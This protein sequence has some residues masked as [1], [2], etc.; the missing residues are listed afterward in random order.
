[1]K[2]EEGNRSEFKFVNSI[3]TGEASKNNRLYGTLG[4]IFGFLF[5][6][7]F[8]VVIESLKASRKKLM[9]E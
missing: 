1:M 6:V 8:I 7:L 3:N 5:S 4:L 9:H 2:L